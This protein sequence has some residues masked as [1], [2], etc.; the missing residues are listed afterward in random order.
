MFR[1]EKEKTGIPGA[2]YISRLFLLFGCLDWVDWYYYFKDISAIIIQYPETAYLLFL[3]ISR[4]SSSVQL[5]N[6]EVK[7]INQIWM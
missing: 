4:Q 7:E 2:C 5:P 6:E 3:I 1:E